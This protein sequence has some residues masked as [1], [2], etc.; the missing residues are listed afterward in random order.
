MVIAVMVVYNNNDNDGDESNDD[1]DDKDNDND[2]NIDAAIVAGAHTP[3][4][5]TTDGETV[6]MTMTIINNAI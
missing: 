3:V 2:D 1:E 4:F 5:A 6:P